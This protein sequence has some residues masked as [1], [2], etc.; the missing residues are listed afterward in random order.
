MENDK[1]STFDKCFTDFRVMFFNRVA[2]NE[3]NTSNN[4]DQT[5]INL[6]K[7]ILIDA[8]FKIY[9]DKYD[10]YETTE[11]NN[12]LVTSKCKKTAKKSKSNRKFCGY[13]LFVHEKS[14]NSKIIGI[15]INLSDISND[16]NMLSPDEKNEYNLRA[17]QIRNKDI[18]DK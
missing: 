5:V 11:T 16:W 17:N 12:S 13:N 2:C 8:K 7:S 18:L 4:I 9:L 14:H 3:H 15:K 1:S 10:S 6:I